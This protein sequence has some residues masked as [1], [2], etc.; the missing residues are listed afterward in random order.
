MRL[1]NRHQY[2][3]Y[4]GF[5]SIAKAFFPPAEPMAAVS[6]KSRSFFSIRINGFSGVLISYCVS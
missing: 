6:Q 4:G 1:A 3:T 5:F 2:Y